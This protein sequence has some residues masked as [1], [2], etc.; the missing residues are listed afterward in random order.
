M[1]EANSYI[2]IDENNEGIEKGDLVN[3]VFF[4]SMIWDKY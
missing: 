4:N 1:V 3:L 2:I